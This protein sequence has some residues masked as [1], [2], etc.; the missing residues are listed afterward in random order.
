MT[1]A[2]A[3]GVEMSENIAMIV[4]NASVQQCYKTSNVTTLLVIGFDN[5]KFEQCSICQDLHQFKKSFY[6]HKRLLQAILLEQNF[7]IPVDVS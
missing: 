2:F 3:I 4:T 6:L 5:E 7:Q 1:T